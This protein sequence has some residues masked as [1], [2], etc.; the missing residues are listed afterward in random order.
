MQK[1]RARSLLVGLRIGFLVEVEKEKEG[2]VV[3][4]HP[5]FC[6][7]QVSAPST[8]Q[9]KN[10]ILILPSRFYEMDTIRIERYTVLRVQV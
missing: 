8:L 1:R 6:G 9:F 2:F 5:N 7:S 3:Y 4:I 10:I